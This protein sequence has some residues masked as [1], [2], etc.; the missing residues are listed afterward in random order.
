MNQTSAAAEYVDG[1]SV[2]WYAGSMDRLLDGA[3]GSPYMHRLIY[4][5]NDKIILI[6]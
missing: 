6:F 5:L 3:L 2:H 4:K 1:T